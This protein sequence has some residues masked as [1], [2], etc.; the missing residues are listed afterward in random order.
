MDSNTRATYAIQHAIAV[1]LTALL[2]ISRE[3]AAQT[4]PMS[5]TL[6]DIGGRRLHLDCRGEGRPS[7]VV[8]NG[9]GAFSIDWA[10]VQPEVAKFTRICTYDRAGYAWSD[11]SALRNLPDEVIADLH[12]LLKTALIERPAV[13][14]GQSIGGIL[15]RDYQRR[16][17]EHVAGLVLVD[18]THDEGLAYIINGKPK[19]ITEISREELAA[20]MREYLARPP[21][22][23]PTPIVIAA[24]FDRLP[25]NLHSVR[26]WAQARYLADT[27]VNMTAYIGEGQRQ[28]FLALRNLRRA[29]QHALGSLPLA[30]LTNGAN[31]RK[32]ELVSLS[33]TGTLLVAE[34]SCHEIHLCSPDLVVRAIRDVVGR[35][36]QAAPSPQ[37]LPAAQPLEEFSLLT[38]SVSATTGATPAGARGVARSR[39]RGS[40]TA[41]ER[42]P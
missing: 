34:K 12:L 28:Q 38:L 30:V 42:T 27:D 14:V 4:P 22:P 41:G 11:P 26:L 23:R 2:F 19:P 40:P 17:P 20:F 7:V 31:A 15:V 6:V 16:F 10:L 39:R 5:G 3:H 8:E 36:R 35:V 33:E 24:P 25:S 9:G 21:A 1:A 18:P 37:R 29:K 32:A 13:L